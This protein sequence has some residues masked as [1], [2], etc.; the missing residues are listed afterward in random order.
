MPPSVIYGSKEPVWGTLPTHGFWANPGNVAWIFGR[1]DDKGCSRTYGALIWVRVHAVNRFLFTKSLTDII[2][3]SIL[4]AMQWTHPEL[5]GDLPSMCRAHWATLVGR[6]IVLIDGRENA[7]Y[8]NNLHVFE[9]PTRSWSCPTFTTEDVLP[10][11]RAHT[12]VLYSI[13]ILCFVVEC[14]ASPG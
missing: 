1:C 11:R 2:F 7:P 3:Y 12:K 8:Y 4:E 5:Q 10:P 13:K 14:A 9:I 6:K